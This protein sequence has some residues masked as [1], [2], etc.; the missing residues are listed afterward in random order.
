[1]SKPLVNPISLWRSNDESVSARLSI[2]SPKVFTQDFDVVAGS[3]EEQATMSDMRARIEQAHAA[4]IKSMKDT[5]G[6]KRDQLYLPFV[7]PM[8][9]APRNSTLVGVDDVSDKEEE[10]PMRS[11]L[12]TWSRTA[13]ALTTLAQQVA[14]R[15]RELGKDAQEMQNPSV[16][17]TPNSNGLPSEAEEAAFLSIYTKLLGLKI[18]DEAERH[19]DRTRRMLERTDE[20]TIPKT[21][22]RVV[23]NLDDGNTASKLLGVLAYPLTTVMRGVIPSARLKF[24]EEHRVERLG[25]VLESEVLARMTKAKQSYFDSSNYKGADL[26]NLTEVAT[27]MKT[28]EDMARS[29]ENYS[30]L[31]VGARPNNTY[32]DTLQSFVEFTTTTARAKG[33]EGTLVW[34][35]EDFRQTLAYDQ[36]MREAQARM[37]RADHPILE[38]SPVEL[39]A[40]LEGGQEDSKASPNNDD[41][42]VSEGQTDQ[43]PLNSYSI[44]EDRWNKEKGMW[45]KIP[46]RRIREIAES[47]T[48]QLAEARFRRQS[49]RITETENIRNLKIGSDTH[50]TR[51]PLPWDLLYPAPEERSSRKHRHTATLPKDW[52]ETWLRME[53]MKEEFSREP[54]SDVAK[55]PASQPVK[56][57]TRKARKVASVID[58][59]AVSANEEDVQTGS[60]AKS[61]HHP[62]VREEMDKFVL[63]P[64]QIH[65][66]VVDILRRLAQSVDEPL[67]SDEDPRWRI[68]YQD[69]LA[70]HLGAGMSGSTIHLGK[71]DMLDWPLP[72]QGVHTHAVSDNAHGYDPT[73]S[74]DDT[75]MKAWNWGGLPDRSVLQRRNSLP[76][77]NEVNNAVLSASE[78]AKAS[79]D[80]RMEYYWEGERKL[81]SMMR[82][83]SGNDTSS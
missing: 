37:H 70:E 45:T 73:K 25:R 46:T 77:P 66:S 41:L 60:L 47:M 83:E 50:H 38:P 82:G 12:S 57:R 21:T 76:V 28:S 40:D 22:A 62:D 69:A 11:H 6:K 75:D 42:A 79:A 9:K 26:K 43:A 68:A 71:S 36:S 7:R 29:M 52:Y 31:L 65:P 5:N 63:E 51:R 30:K 13:E 3:P 19:M 58:N 35:M 53:R 14:D 67:T 61:D 10:D 4:V 78:W 54:R 72:L 32:E 1:M 39:V 64:I 8:T 27:L 15:W 59:S 34:R 18:I 23:G 20:D 74:R 48:K 2:N 80:A 81:F 56:S 49:E 16:L 33:I 44:S 17:H 55:P 24:E